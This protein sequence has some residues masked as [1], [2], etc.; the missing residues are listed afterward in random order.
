MNTGQQ[1]SYYK[2]PGI[3]RQEGGSQVEHA[4]LGGLETEG[5]PDAG[6]VQ[7]LPVEIIEQIKIG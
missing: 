3:R 4:W 1:G 2:E 5:E 6:T 7:I